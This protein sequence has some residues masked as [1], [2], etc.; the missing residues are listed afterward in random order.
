MKGAH[1]NRN[2]FRRRGGFTLIELLVVIAIIAILIGLLLP[3]VQKVRE[4]AARTQSTNNLKQMSLALANHT[5][6]YAGK[7]PPGLGTY[8]ST[9]GANIQTFFTWLLPGIEQD[10]IFK[11][12]AGAT[13][14]VAA[15][16]ST[17]TIKTYQ[18][19][20]DI[21]NPAADARLS[22]AV[23]GRV[24]G[25]NTGKG[26]AAFYPGTFNQKGTSNTIFV[27][28]RFSQ[29]DGGAAAPT[30]TIYWYSP[31]TTVGGDATTVFLYDCPAANVGNN[32]ANPTFGVPASTTNLATL[33]TTA[34]GYG[35]SSM[36]VALFDG[37]ART[38]TPSVT[39][40]CPAP[41]STCTVWSWA[42]SITSTANNTFGN[43]PPPPDW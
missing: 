38:V 42:C 21:T 43:A 33:Q 10:N 15:N 26:P 11:Q 13:P 12:C 4:A 18:A 41:N 27:F 25:G 1:V 22:Y 35:S 30:N 8:P 28:E 34:N 9:S 3:A 14:P 31:G 24:V 36:Q 39:N 29:P 37:S 7:V 20:L 17:W 2:V 23:N 16:N 5:A 32:C 19:P 6:L 40:M